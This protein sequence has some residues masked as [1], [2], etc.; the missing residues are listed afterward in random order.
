M[1]ECEDSESKN[2]AD[3]DGN[4][5]LNIVVHAHDSG[6]QH[7]LSANHEDIGKECSPYDDVCDFCE[8][9][10][11][12]SAPRCLPNMLRGERPDDAG[13]RE[14]HPLVDGEDAVAFGQPSE[15]GEI[16]GVGD[17]CGKTK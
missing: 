6:S 10:R 2:D 14:K 4:D 5:G 9:D 1:S 13:G 12:E 16:D 17:L 3:N 11:R 15:D 7:L 8:G